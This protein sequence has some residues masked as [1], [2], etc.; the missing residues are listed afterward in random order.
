MT[1]F[2]DQNRS[3]GAGS[4]LV[5]GQRVG[6]LTVDDEAS[7]L[8]GLAYFTVRDGKRIASEMPIRISPDTD[9]RERFGALRASVRQVSSLPVSF[10]AMF[11]K[12]QHEGGATESTEPPAV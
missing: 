2:M 4:Y 1:E 9:D 3:C 7:P 11:A 5:P 12:A 6:T 8:V 10:D